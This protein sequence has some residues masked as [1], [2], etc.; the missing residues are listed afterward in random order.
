ME[1][2]TAIPPEWSETFMMFCCIAA[3]L[4]AVIMARNLFLY[5]PLGQPALRIVPSVSVMVPARNE[6]E[7]IRQLLESVLRCEGVDLEVLVWDDGSTDRTAQVVRSFEL[8]DSRVRLLSGIGLP[9]GWAGKQHACQRLSE[10]AKGDVLVFLD[11]DVRLRRS[12][13][14]WRIAGAFLRQDLDLLSGVPLQRT[15]TFFEKLIVP[16]IHFVLIGFLPIDAMRKTRDPGFAAGCGQLMAFRASAYREVGGHA[17]VR[18]S[19]HEGITLTRLFRAAGKTTELFDAQDL[20]SCR[21][22]RGLREV[23][24]GFA[25]NAHEGLASPKSVLPM[26]ILL[27]FGQ[28]FPSLSL[29]V[30]ALSG[31]F[32]GDWAYWALAALGLGIGARAVV[33]AWFSQP[34]LI[35]LLQ[36]FAVLFLL[37]NQWYGATRT[38]LGMPVGWRGRTVVR[39][40]AKAASNA[41][42]FC[43]FFGV[44]AFGADSLQA[45]R[46]PSMQLEDQ[47][48]RAQVIQFPRER[49]A[50]L[51]I[52]GRHG[53]GEIT[54]WV[55]PVRATFGESVDIIGLA[56]V[57]G[58]PGMFRPAVRAMVRKGSEW[59][60]LMDWTGE[61]VGSIFM[62]GA[63][64][65]VLVLS[66]TGQILTRVAGPVTDE[67]LQKVKERFATI[68]P[69]AAL[70]K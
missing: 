64:I 29:M 45:Q 40:V 36:P 10:A 30:G 44:A 59:P 5:R 2:I 22:Y 65:E 66:K 23:W 67:G 20:C 24:D 62:P 48:A 47:H 4:P 18:D 28:V 39:G 9:A 41:A 11:A 70:A 7:N 17:A 21:M 34:L 15:D 68:V 31:G 8:S 57:H 53:T 54:K 32:S 25:K 13:A 49:P 6:E 61:T 16:M 58:V 51:V 52:A 55:K 63:D 26:S 69:K 43:A 14:L 37:F 42:L 35:A 38:A 27:F 33:S 56:D 1:P 19:F 60:V 12:D 3:A 50:F 46:C